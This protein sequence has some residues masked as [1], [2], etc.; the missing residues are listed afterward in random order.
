VRA[1]DEIPSAN[2][3]M[4]TAR[5]P[6]AELFFTISQPGDHWVS[7]SLAVIAAVSALG[8]DLA[9][10]GLALADFGGLAGRGAQHQIRVGDGTALIIDESYNANPA[11]MAAT[12]AVL[13]RTDAKRHI[14]VLGEMRELGSDSASYHSGLATPLTS[15]NADFAL[16][17]GE[18]MTPLA[19][20]LEGRIDC[21]HV[22]DA[23]TARDLLTSMLA[24]GDAVLIKG[25][26]AVGLSR[27]VEALA[28]GGS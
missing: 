26:N 2:G 19:K 21:A 10:A 4:V 24:P 15:A 11:S 27:I 7:N 17:V 22:A 25:S 18:A 23:A 3:T 12:L 6:D 16:L 9:A 14:A 20:A 28:G 8:G 1:M 13:G 5:L